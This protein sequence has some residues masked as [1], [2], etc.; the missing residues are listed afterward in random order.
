MRISFALRWHSRPH[1]FGYYPQVWYRDRIA[2]KAFSESG[3]LLVEHADPG[4]H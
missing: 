2:D 1:T 3:S 4:Q